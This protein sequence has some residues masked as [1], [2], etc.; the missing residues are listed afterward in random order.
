MRLRTRT[1]RL[2]LTLIY[3]GVFLVSA[4]ALLTLGYLLVR[5]NLDRHH[6]FRAEIDG[7][8][9]AVYHSLF[10]KPLAANGSRRAFLAG[11]Q[12]FDSYRELMPRLT[13]ALRKLENC[14]F[15]GIKHGRESL[16]RAVATLTVLGAFF[17]NQSVGSSA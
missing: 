14:E 7:L 5:H 10:G 3:G 15:T 17:T 12:R 8:G 6:S 16:E 11:H 1:I 4:S 2:R 9:A 13:P